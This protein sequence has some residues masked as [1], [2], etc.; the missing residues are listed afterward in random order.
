MKMRL[1]PRI[2]LVALLQGLSYSGS[3]DAVGPSSFKNS[4]YSGLSRNE[5]KRSAQL[6]GSTDMNYMFPV[7]KI[8]N[9]YKAW[10]PIDYGH[11]LVDATIHYA[12][13][14]LERV[15]IG[16]GPVPPR[17]PQ[18]NRNLVFEAAREV[19]GRQNNKL[20]ANVY[21]SPGIDK[22]YKGLVPRDTIVTI[23]SERRNSIIHQDQRH[24]RTEGNRKKDHLK[25]GIYYVDDPYEKF[26]EK[27]KKRNPFNEGFQT[28]GD[29][30]FFDVSEYPSDEPSDQNSFQD[31]GVRFIPVSLLSTPPTITTTD[32]PYGEIVNKDFY[33]LSTRG[34][35]QKPETRKL[36]RKVATKNTNTLYPL[37]NPYQ[38]SNRNTR[39]QYFPEQSP[40]SNSYPLRL[41]GV[42]GPRR[43]EVEE[44]PR[45]VVQ[46]QSKTGSSWAPSD[47]KYH[48]KGREIEYRKEPIIYQV[49]DSGELVAPIAENIYIAN[50]NDQASSGSY[51]WSGSKEPQEK[52][53]DLPRAQNFNATESDSDHSQPEAYPVV[54]LQDI[55][56]KS[57]L[58]GTTDDLFAGGIYAAGQL[59]RGPARQGEYDQSDQYDTHNL[60][61]GGYQGDISARSVKEEMTH[62]GY[63]PAQIYY[64]CTTEVPEYLQKDLCKLPQSLRNAETSFTDRSDNN[65]HY[66]KLID[67][68]RVPHTAII[69]ER[70]GA[71]SLSSS[72]TFPSKQGTSGLA[73]FPRNHGSPTFFSAGTQTHVIETQTT[74]YDSS[75]TSLRTVSVRLPPKPQ[76]QFVQDN[77]YVSTTE[78]MLQERAL[79]ELTGDNTHN[80]ISADQVLSSPETPFPYVKG[81]TNG[82]PAPII[83]SVAQSKVAVYRPNELTTSTVPPISSSSTQPVSSSTARPF[84][85]QTPLTSTPVYQTGP[86][87]NEYYS[88]SHFGKHQQHPK[89]VRKR[90]LIYAKRR[91]EGPT[92]V[93][94][95]FEYL[96]RL[97]HFLSDRVFT[98]RT[99][100]RKKSGE[101][102]A[103]VTRR[104]EGG[105]S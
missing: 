100:L 75:L 77:Q 7:P 46:F 20:K 85:Y 22:P 18:A 35:K 105:V 91:P 26:R 6:K 43:P 58:E 32:R 40:T 2:I 44:S 99:K 80:V 30:R 15:H 68:A 64:L 4:N 13:P 69:D 73:T 79:P 19:D 33:D 41:E 94:R 70:H 16:K 45:H 12:P 54:T 29:D 87:S 57:G 50:D 81:P 56:S 96:S 3:S 59:A 36:G 25:S 10:K 71:P 74:A 95:P 89:L 52:L 62:S 14:E 63:S 27:T 21:D 9:V 66:T 103:L 51:H 5:R 53:S 31:A 98:G 61:N 60:A 92:Q 47:N 93:S 78:P 67:K 8:Q 76:F 55:A 39:P 65:V 23:P 102:P 34:K 28:M 97:S 72:S 86:E 82:G 104:L 1:I 84:H 11:P 17:P 88:Q 101:F 37:G 48:G 83:Y 42:L 38:G 90:P 24:G 49:K